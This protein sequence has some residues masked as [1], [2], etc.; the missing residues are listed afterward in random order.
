MALKKDKTDVP[1]VEEQKNDTVDEQKP[2][3]NEEQP[4][5]EL[6]S[7]EE[8]MVSGYNEMMEQIKKIFEKAEA[9]TRPKIVQAIE[10]AK[11]HAVELN[12]LTQEEAHKIGEFI[13]R[14]INDA[15]EFLAESEDDLSNWF[16]FDIQLIE[17]WLW[18]AFS[19]V[20]DKTRL[21]LM[22]IS[23]RLEHDSKYHTGEVTGPGT[24][25]CAACGKQ[26]SFKK[27]GRIP[28]CGGCRGT[29]F[30]RSSNKSTKKD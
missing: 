9:Q 18:E 1:P 26:M 16:Q 6:R 13:R 7:S 4:P 8:R 20:A 25:K 14:D 27:T 22:A 28:P 23:E 15:A 29:E 21:E 3:E 19:S 12:K 24:L 5:E 17:N 2:S 30:E 10:T 11:K